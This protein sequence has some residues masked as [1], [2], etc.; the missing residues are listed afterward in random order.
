MWHMNKNES[1]RF[2][3]RILKLTLTVVFQSWREIDEK[4]EGDK[5][6]TAGWYFNFV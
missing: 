1:V 4:A 6:W 5:I 3:Y 2:F